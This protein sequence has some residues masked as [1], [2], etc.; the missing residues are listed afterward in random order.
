MFRHVH[1]VG[2][3]SEQY[4]NAVRVWGEPDFVH[5]FHD[6]RMYGD[7]DTENDTVVLGNKGHDLPN[8][9]YSWQDHELY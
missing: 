9:K 8:P 4:A 1:F 5:S 3:R 2:V 7:V 6:R